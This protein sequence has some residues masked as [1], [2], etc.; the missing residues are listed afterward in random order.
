[1]INLCQDWSAERL[2]KVEGKMDEYMELANAFLYSVPIVLAG[3]GFSYVAWNVGQAIIMDKNDSK[4]RNKL[5]EKL[6]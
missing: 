5:K 1:M 4:K 6:K 2:K 3:I